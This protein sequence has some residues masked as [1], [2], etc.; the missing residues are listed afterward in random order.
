MSPKRRGYFVGDTE[1]ARRYLANAAA[2]G[3]W[4]PQ[5]PLGEYKDGQVLRKANA[6]KIQEQAGV[7]ISNKAARGHADIIPQRPL[8][9][10]SGKRISGIGAAPNGTSGKTEGMRP[11][12][13]KVRK[14]VT[15][16]PPPRLP[17]DQRI[18]GARGSS[19]LNTTKFANVLKE[20]KQVQRER[21]D[22]NVYFKLWDNRLGEWRKLYVYKGAFNSQNNGVSVKELLD[23]VREKVKSGRAKTER[24]GLL[25]V[26]Q[27]DVEGDVAGEDTPDDVSM[28]EVFTIFSVHVMAG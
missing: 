3:L 2:A 10:P 14:D 4:I 13:A 23:R 11:V 5:K 19:Q 22:A 25:Q 9:T 8:F 21:G 6:F 18:Q 7:P 27:E 24:E 1:G 15:I 28:P 20:L 26:W 17:M 16:I 12:I